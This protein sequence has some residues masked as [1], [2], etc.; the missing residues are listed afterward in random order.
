MTFIQ[1]LWTL[2]L[3]VLGGIL[4]RLAGSAKTGDWLDW[5]RNTKA[6]DV[7]VALCFCALTVILGIVRTGVEWL[8]LIPTFLGM[9]GALST[10]RYFLPKPKDYQWYHYAMHGFFT[11]LAAFPLALSTWYW[12]G[13]WIR[14][15]LCTVL[16]SL[17]SHFCTKDT[18]EERGRGFILIVTTPLLLIC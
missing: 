4:Y 3:S 5:A 14:V 9:M 8:T 7:G 2:G 10:Y 13:F 1:T 18:W 17:W 12:K 16:I 11:S 15:A 6:R